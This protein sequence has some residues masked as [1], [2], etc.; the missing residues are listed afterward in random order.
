MPD[1]G[2]D[3]SA[4]NLNNENWNSNPL[5]SWTQNYLTNPGLGGGW[6]DPAGGLNAGKLA[7]NAS[8]Q[9]EKDAFWNALGSAYATPASRQGTGYEFL[10]AAMMNGNYGVPQMMDML[11]STLGYE[12]DQSARQQAQD[13]LNQLKTQGAADLGRYEQAGNAYFQPQIARFQGMT[14]NN[15]GGIRNDAEYGALLANQEG[16]INAQVNAANTQ[17]TRDS[18]M[19]GV[20]DSGKMQSNARWTQLGGA[21]AKGQLFQGL[22]SDVQN[23]LQG[24]QQGQVDFQG[25][26]ASRR[27]QLNAGNVSAAQNLGNFQN[28]YGIQ[29]TKIG[30]GTTADFNAAN[31]GQTMN[32][33]A[34]AM[35]F[36]FGMAGIGQNAMSQ[37][38]GMFSKGGR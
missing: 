2:F 21:Q 1:F 37:I 3:F 14:A 29:N 25:D 19:R 20:S 30:L 13:S 27:A 10:R 34:Q 26:L 38:G 17:A 35:Q 33:Q 12:Q 15:Y 18:A 36:G 32:N 22:G 8:T 7:P 6:T 31:Y 11:Q 16:A 23:K 9:G 4:Q 5:N 28:P 24:L